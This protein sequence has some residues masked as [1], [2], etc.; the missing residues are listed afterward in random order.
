M[1]NI[2]K[3]KI[4]IL[5]FIT[6]VILI[7][8]GFSSRKDSKINYGSN[9]I[10]V[11]L[12]PFQ[13]FIDYSFS[14]IGGFFTHFGDAKKLKE[15]NEKLKEK[16]VLLENQIQ[17]LTEYE[18]ENKKLKEALNI[19]EQFDDYLPLGSNIIG[20]DM[21]N[22]FNVFTIDR[23]SKDG[24]SNDFAVITHKGLVGRV[25]STGLMSSKV[26]SIIDEGSSVSARIFK[27]KDLV[28][29]KGDLKLKEQGFCKMEYIPPD[30][31][32]A[33]GDRIVTSGLG[34]IY[35]KGITIGKV[36]EIRRKT[37]EI[38]RYA[39]IEPSVDFKRLEA[40]FVLKSKN[41]NSD[42]GE[43]TQ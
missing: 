27:T 5:S 4:F 20:K 35:P 21:G 8:M 13:Q 10:S 32:I 16:I 28:V 43:D 9:I 17:Q 31:D 3:S 19:K 23:G 14:G 37:S 1:R 42:K 26:I 12:S 18:N 2:L 29:V 25:I 33:V 7:V 41:I 15:E 36:V 6:V 22:W 34:G 30:V 38:N 11:V 39:I 24:V 40:V